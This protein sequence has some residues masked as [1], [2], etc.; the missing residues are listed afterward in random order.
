MV[1]WF[2]IDGEFTEETAALRNELIED[3]RPITEPP[4]AIDRRDQ[5]LKR[6]GISRC[7]M[8]ITRDY[9]ES[10]LLKMREFEFRANFVPYFA[11]RNSRPIKNE[12]YFT[13]WNSPSPVDRA[14]KLQRLTLERSSARDLKN[15]KQ[16]LLL[17]GKKRVVLD[18]DFTARDA[19]NIRRN[20]YQIVL[21]G[22]ITG[23]IFTL[24]RCRLQRC[25]AFFIARQRRL[26]YCRTEH[27]RE[28]HDAKLQK[29]SWREEKHMLSDSV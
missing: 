8:D 21:E 26:F 12:A 23:K 7:S 6:V 11:D 14:G 5:R 9:L 3:L 17:C 18:V 13:W 25:A 4:T 1:V 16:K 15:G 20:Y 29:E 19:S 27:T 22:L 10:L 28:S 2:R 24:R